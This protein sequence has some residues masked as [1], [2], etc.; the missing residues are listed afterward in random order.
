MTVD[1][2][3]WERERGIGV[4]P[5][6]PKAKRSMSIAYTPEQSVGAGLPPE[7]TVGVRLSGALTHMRPRWNGK[8]A[9]P[10]D[11]LNNSPFLLLGS[12]YALTTKPV[13]ALALECPAA[14]SMKPGGAVSV[15]KLH[16]EEPAQPPAKSDPSLRNNS[17]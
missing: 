12:R 11:P 15:G 4:P 8:V 3:A 17:E 1:D 10:A 5:K 14:I 2:G 13:P 16:C 9:R 7:L 6:S